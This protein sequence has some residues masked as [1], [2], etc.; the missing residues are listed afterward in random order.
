MEHDYV[1]IV[2]EY[3]SMTDAVKNYQEQKTGPRS[4]IS[5][6]QVDQ[7]SSAAKSAIRNV[8]LVHVCMSIRNING[9]DLLPTLSWTLILR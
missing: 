6:K 2:T 9:V 3:A 1:N 5:D 8:I 4:R 7:R